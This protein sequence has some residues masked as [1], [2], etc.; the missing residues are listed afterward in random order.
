MIR[1]HLGF[2]LIEVS[3]VLVIISL[4]ITGAI[5]GL[6]LIQSVKVKNAIILVQDLSLA[7]NTFKQK[8]HMLPGDIKIVSQVPNVRS[9]CSSGGSNVGDNNGLIDTNE[10]MCVPE[11]LFH[12]GL[13]KVNQSNGWAE[14]DSNYGPVRVLAV[15]KSNV[16]SSFP[17]SNTNVAEF[18]NLPC[19]VVQEIDRKIDNDNIATGMAIASD[20]TCT[21]GSIVAYYA[22]V[23]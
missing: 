9:E 23:L 8:Y 11:V 18:A 22:M 4:L 20:A 13:A 10:S 17:T 3:I 5:K 2:T 6:H 19:E 14:F 7:V 16:S 15:S 21:A 1:R 12:A